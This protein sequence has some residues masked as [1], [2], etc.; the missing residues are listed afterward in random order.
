MA[1]LTTRA[2]RRLIEKI[3]RDEASELDAVAEVTHY[4]NYAEQRQRKPDDDDTEDD[5]KIIET[6]EQT[7]TSSS[8]RLPAEQLLEKTLRSR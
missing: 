5:V 8:S 7:N 6:I 2:N 4:I 3:L 1:A